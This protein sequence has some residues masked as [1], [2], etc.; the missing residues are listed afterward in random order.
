MHYYHEYHSSLN[1]NLWRFSTAAIGKFNVRT[2]THTH[3]EIKYHLIVVQAST[4]DGVLGIKNEHFWSV[5]Y[6]IYV[7]S[8]PYHI[9]PV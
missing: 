4:L 5:T 2:H 3:T 9:V 8:T 6:G 1:L 7:S